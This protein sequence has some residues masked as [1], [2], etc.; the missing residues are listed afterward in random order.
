M[1]PFVLLPRA[2]FNSINKS[3]N[4]EF[5]FRKGDIFNIKDTMYQ[6]LI[7]SWHA[8]RV[9][10]KG[11]LL[12]KGILPNKSRYEI[13]CSSSAESRKLYGSLGWLFPT[14]FYGKSIIE[15]NFF[16]VL[17]FIKRV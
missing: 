4:N 16:M 10:K 6:G 11:E 14:R 2:N 8:K 7:G 12:D 5:S 13:S 9:G 1:N 15:N 3:S 17:L